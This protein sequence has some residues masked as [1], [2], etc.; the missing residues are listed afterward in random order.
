[1]N[2]KLIH[3][4]LKSNN[5]VYFFCPSVIKNTCGL[6]L[7]EFS[8]KRRALSP[9]KM[10]DWWCH[11][12]CDDLNKCYQNT[13]CLYASPLFFRLKAKSHFFNTK[14]GL[15][16]LLNALGC[17]GD[18]IVYLQRWKTSFPTA[19]M[20][21]NLVKHTSSFNKLSEKDEIQI[22]LNE[23]SAVIWRVVR[24]GDTCEMLN[25]TAERMIWNKGWKYVA[26]LKK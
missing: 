8:M 12:V 24:A 18:C 23:Q 1:M 25:T 5:S 7:R 21:T 19:K 17:S 20:K 6:N 16:L 9:L 11:F 2:I 13:L 15:K 22:T 26:G 4:D 3:K 10:S 14:K